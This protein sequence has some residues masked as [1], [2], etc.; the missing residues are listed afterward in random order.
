MLDGPAKE[1]APGGR[2][3][4][5]AYYIMESLMAKGIF[6]MKQKASGRIIFY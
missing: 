5:D 6:I 4:S 3:V 1:Y 2:T